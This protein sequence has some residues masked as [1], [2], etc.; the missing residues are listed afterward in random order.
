MAHLES[1]VNSMKEDKSKGKIKSVHIEIAENG[2]KYCVHTDKMN[3]AQYVYTDV[4]DVLKAL[5]DD[6]STPY[7]RKSKVGI[8]KRF[9]SLKSEL[10][11]R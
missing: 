9:S 6:L 1:V 4:D 3:D 2:F 10:S 5:K 8:G 7:L 11:R